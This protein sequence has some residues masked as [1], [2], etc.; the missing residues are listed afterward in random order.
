MQRSFVYSL[1]LILVLLSG[2]TAGCSKSDKGTNPMPT[3]EPFD[4]GNLASN[5]ASTFV[6]VFNTA[7]SYGYRCKIHSSMTGTINVTANAADSAVIDIGNTFFSPASASIKP[8]GY[9]RW[10]SLTTTVHT[11]TR[12]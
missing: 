11:V 8:T 1:M 4:S 2:L 10:I 7:G 12:P 3:T 5:A 9:A 6:H